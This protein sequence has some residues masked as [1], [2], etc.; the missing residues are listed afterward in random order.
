VLAGAG[1]KREETLLTIQA[2]FIM[3]N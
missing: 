2:N 1:L 3:M